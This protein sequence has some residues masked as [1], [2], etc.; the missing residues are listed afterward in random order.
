MLVMDQ[1]KKSLLL[2]ANDSQLD[3]DSVEIVTARLCL[4]PVTE[5]YAADIFREFTPD[6]TRYMVPST[7][8]EIGETKAFIADTT[9]QR[10]LGVDLVLVI[11]SKENEEFLGCCGLH[12]AQK[13]T[14]PELGIW[15]KKSAHGSGFGREAIAAL[16]EWAARNLTVEALIYPVDRKNGPSRNIPERMGGTIIGEARVKT[17]SG[18]ELDEVVYRIPIAS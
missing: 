3:L 14:E 16:A 8:R 9:R 10:K 2:A 15:L 17:M 7:P 12:G 4:R 13:A 1:S 5:R 18:T 6:V 11:L